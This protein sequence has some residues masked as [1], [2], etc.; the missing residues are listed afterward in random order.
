[1]VKA[2]ALAILAYVAAT[3]AVQ[4][5]SHFL[6]GAEH[7]ASVP[8]MR[9]DPII[10]LGLLSM[11]IQG[12]VFSALSLRAVRRERAYRDAMVFAWLVGAV[13]VS[14]IALGEAGKY[15]VPAIDRWIGQEVV[16]GFLQFSLYGALL[17][18]V[19]AKAR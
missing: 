8:F 16:A 13:I 15:A 11:L 7:Y 14:Y 2:H 17:G 10:A 1:M 6:L 12:A 3:F 4:A 9:K 18:L 5:T 19:H